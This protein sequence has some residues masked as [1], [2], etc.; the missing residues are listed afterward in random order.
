M[1]VDDSLLRP[2]SVYR[3]VRVGTATTVDTVIR[4]L[5]S[6]SNTAGL[7][8]ALVRP[9][10]QDLLLPGQDCLLPVVDKMDRERGEYR[11]SQTYPQKQDLIQL[12]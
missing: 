2:D 5:A 1:R 3:S 8:L 4:L 12:D 11:H 7:R 6:T 9:D 10:L